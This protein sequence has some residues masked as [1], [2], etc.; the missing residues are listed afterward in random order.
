VTFG[1]ELEGGLERSP[2]LVAA[3]LTGIGSPLSR[4]A[5]TSDSSSGRPLFGGP[6]RGSRPSAT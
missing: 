5:S 2:Q 3:F 4:S 6:C 1:H